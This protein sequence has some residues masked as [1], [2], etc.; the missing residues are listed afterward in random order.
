TYH[1]RFRQYMKMCQKQD[2]AVAGNITDA[3]GDRSLPPHAQPDPDL[4]VRIVE[5]NKDGIVVNGAKLQQSGAPIAHERL[6]VPT[7]ALGPRDE[8]Y[9]VAFAVP[10][11]APGVIHINDTACVN[12]KF[13][14]MDPEDIGNVTFGMHQSAHVLF[15]HV[16]VPWE[17]VFLCGEWEATRDLVHRFSDFQRFAS[18]ACRCG[19]MDLCIG[20]ASAMA[21]YNG[22]ADKSHIRDK[23]VDMSI[24][25]ETLYGLTAGSAALAVPTPSGVVLPDSLTVNAAKLFMNDALLRCAQRL[26]EIGG[27]ILVTRPSVKDLKI[28][29]VGELLW[30]YHA[31]KQGT[32][33]E[34]RIKMARLCESLA[35]LASPTPILSI[36]AAGPPATQRLN[37]RL[38]TDFTRNRKAAERL[39]GINHKP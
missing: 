23:L 1:T 10:G 25:T 3:K 37:F 31:G 22:V 38:M 17:R 6:V 18:S 5:K 32:A 8:P 36:I 20:A 35:G 30:K 33:T 14:A 13:K 39:A 24:D 34:D 16:F 19:Y 27:G 11:D 7:M 12:A 4:F 9:A 21:E 15:D 2:L 28:P 26:A 29:G